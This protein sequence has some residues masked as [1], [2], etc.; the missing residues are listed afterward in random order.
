MRPS[1]MLL[2]FVLGS[3]G[4]I[5]FGLLGVAFV[6]FMLGPEHPELKSEIGPLMTH[7]GRFAALTAA[8]AVSFEGLLR[9]RSWRRPGVGI[10]LLVL[11]AVV[12]AYTLE[13][14]G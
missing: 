8:A 2:G 6:F 13:A 5:C 3:S 11:A 1:V 4:A 9:Q 10:L 7:L 12:A 14:R